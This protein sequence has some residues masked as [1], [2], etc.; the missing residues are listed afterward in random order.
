MRLFSIYFILFFFSL[1]FPL[2]A[3]DLKDNASHFDPYQK[4]FSKSEIEEKI[5]K[6]LLK[7]AQV[8][9]FYTL[10]E[11][12]LKIYSSPE[13]KVKDQPEFILELGTEPKKETHI[14]IS[15]DPHRPLNGMRIAIDPGHFG[16]Q[17]AKLE[18]KYIDMDPN[19][20]FGIYQPIQ[21]DE[22]T[23]ATETAKRLAS[24]LQALGAQI[25]LTR[26][27]P[28]ETVYR[29][30][31][32]TWLQQDFDSAIEKMIALQ[33]D[34]SLREKEKIFWRE[35]ATPTEIFRS[36]YAYV[37]LQ[38]RADLI[39]AFKPHVT[40]SCHYN[41]GGIYDKDGKTPGTTDDYTLFFIPG[42]YMRGSLKDE[43]FR[44]TSMKDARSRYEFIRLLVTDS[45]E[46]SIAL[47]KV[48]QKNLYKRLKLPPGDHCSYLKVLCLQN[49]PGIYHRNLMLPRLVHSPVLYAE[50]FCQDNYENAKTLDQNPDLLIDKMVEVYTK[51]ILDWSRE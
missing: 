34:T 14:P 49:S 35:K 27:Q 6:M 4:T 38:R 11:A 8:E 43:A 23:L 17:Y 24:K 30:P 48:A 28:G 50:P 44:C 22:G 40:V 12:A 13:D 10:T 16:S 31:F 25:L 9:D 21:F 29:K 36:T 18:E 33:P 5:S 51:S 32:Q 45:L 3:L 15:F 42:A 37:D 46:K 7:D 20:T 26:T 2:K 41:L 19:E 47:A 1:A 39:N